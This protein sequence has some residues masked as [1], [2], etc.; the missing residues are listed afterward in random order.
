MPVSDC[1]NK[2]SSGRSWSSIRRNP[3]RSTGTNQPT[4]QPTNEPINSHETLYMEYT[5]EAIMAGL[6]PS[7]PASTA[8]QCAA[9]SRARTAVLKGTR[10]PRRLGPFDAQGCALYH[11]PG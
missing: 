1:S 6:L 10:N 3:L 8:F 11:N 9:A 2:A 7:K 4:N 5:T